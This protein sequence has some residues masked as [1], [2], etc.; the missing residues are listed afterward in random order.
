MW[1]D[2]SSGWI[3]TSISRMVGMWKDK[4]NGWIVTSIS[5]MVGMWKESR[6][7]ELLPVSVGWLSSY[8]YQ[9]DGCD[10]EG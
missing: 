1:K 4:L 2:K 3:V 5:R 6:M 7:V 10:V 9:S 8:Q